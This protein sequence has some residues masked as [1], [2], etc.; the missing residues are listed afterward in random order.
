MN[1]SVWTVCGAIE[2]QKRLEA[3]QPSIPWQRVL[4]EG[5]CPHLSDKALAS[6]L[7]ALESNDPRIITG[8]TTYPPCLD[9]TRA[10]TV[11]MCCPISFTAF[12]EGLHRVGEVFDHFEKLCIAANTHF[13]VP[14]ACRF[15]LGAI[16]DCDWSYMRVEMAAVIR[17][18]LSERAVAAVA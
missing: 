17:G 1:D 3:L 13:S 8:T 14:A 5:F 4:R 18:V 15:L 10:Q 9:L 6:L 12:A 2:E 16:D 11:E 7:G